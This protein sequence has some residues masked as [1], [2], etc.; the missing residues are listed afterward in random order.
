MILFRD[1][2]PKIL[3][4]GLG[5]GLFFFSPSLILTAIGLFPKMSYIDFI[6]KM[7]QSLP[8]RTT[9]SWSCRQPEEGPSVTITSGFACELDKGVQNKHLVHF[10]VLK[11]LIM[12]L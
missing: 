7:D 9:R 6:S 12:G 5:M 2:L 4:K 10:S 3:Q 8:T 1:L 11:T